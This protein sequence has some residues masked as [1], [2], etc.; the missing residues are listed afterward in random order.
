[1][2]NKTIIE[3]T[4]DSSP[5]SGSMILHQLA[6]GGSGSTRKVTIAAATIAGMGAATLA[7]IGNVTIT[8]ISSGEVLSWNGSAWV[9]SAAGTGD[10]TGP[11]TSTDN[12]VARYSGTGNTIQNSVVIIADTTGNMSGVGTLGC[13]AITSTGATSL[14]TLGVGAITGTSTIGGTDI[15]AS[16]ALAGAS[17]AISGITAIT[18]SAD[19]VQLTV[20]GNA[21]N[22]SDL[23]V[24]E[25]SA[26][27]DMFKVGNTGNATLTGSLTTAGVTSSASI[28]I[29]GGSLFIDEGTQLQLNNNGAANSYIS[30]T[31]SQMNIVNLGTNRLVLDGTGALVTGRIRA[32]GDLD[33]A[34]LQV[35]GN[36]SQTTPLILAEQSN[37]TDVFTVS[38]A[39]NTV[40]AGTLGV[41]GA[42]TLAALGVGAITGT[43]TIGGTDI[44]ASG[45]LA[46]A[47]MAGPLTIDVSGNTS[48]MGTLGCGAITSTGAFSA[49]SGAFTLPVT[50]TGSTD[51]VQFTATANATQTSD[52]AQFIDS[53]GNNLVEVSNT[54][55]V[56]RDPG[57][58]AGTNELQVSM[59]T[60]VTAFFNVPA[61]GNFTGFKFGTSAATLVQFTP[62]RFETFKKLSPGSS[63]AVDLGEVAS[64]D[65]RTLYINNIGTLSGAEISILGDGLEA[66]DAN[67]RLRIADTD[68]GA[69]TNA[70]DTAG[71]DIFFKGQSGGAH[72]AANPD[73]GSIVFTPGAAGSG[74]AGAPG[75]VQVAGNQLFT[76]AGL[77]LPFAEIC[78]EGVT[79]TITIAGTG[80]GNKVQVTSF[81]TDG[82]NNQMTP[83]HTN[84]HITADV[85]GTYL[86]NASISFT[87]TGGSSYDMAFGCWKNNGAT[88]F[89]NLLA[90]RSLGGGGSDTGAMSLSGLIDLAATDTLELWCYNITNTNDVII[91]DVT[92]S[93]VQ[94][95]G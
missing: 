34:Q 93:A 44:T 71:V 61:G 39:G 70:A 33:F 81:D 19:V 63:N 23:F 11:G 32:T 67:A 86:V 20:T 21:T 15:T 4:L 60:S 49:T 79:A 85:A 26:A 57:S 46:G 47:T 68:P 27:T 12:A 22:T 72:T 1:M 80:V 29:N 51:A 73:G 40:V 66:S 53:S 52:I 9:N 89:A 92:L 75:Q 13:G 56:V 48:A 2:A 65:W 16:G 69:F 42:T 84:D 87:S 95:G 35:I 54:H 8:G 24:V 30:G 62:T 64:K 76:G 31:S 18:G 10:V 28:D 43:S 82:Q 37:G 55:L 78:A 74:G 5:L 41:T 91:E 94:I 50:V 45:A 6:A 38:N 7:A 17:A 83:D 77:G 25:N 90:E 14:G 59:S 88:Q 58:T 36:A 3:Y